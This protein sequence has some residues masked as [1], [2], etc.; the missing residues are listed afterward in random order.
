MSKG[1]TSGHDNMAKFTQIGGTD[2]TDRCVHFV[3]LKKYDRRYCN[4]YKCT[5]YEVLTPKTLTF[6]DGF[7]NDTITINN[8]VES[9]ILKSV[10]L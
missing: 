4:M 3:S 7:N 1:L 5:S 8:H 10:I 2:Y 9:K 6:S